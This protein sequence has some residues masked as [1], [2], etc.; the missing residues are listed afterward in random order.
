MIPVHFVHQR[1]FA[2]SDRLSGRTGNLRFL[3]WSGTRRRL[4]RLCLRGLR[5]G[6]NRL[7]LLGHWLLRHWLVRGWL[8]QWSR[9]LGLRILLHWCLRLRSDCRGRGRWRSRRSRSRLR[10]D[11]TGRALRAGAGH[12]RHLLWHLEFHAT[13]WAMKSNRL[14]RLHRERMGRKGLQSINLRSL[15]NLAWCII[16]IA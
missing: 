5:R 2:G 16:W 13:A 15:V 8:L 7:L 12:A 3:K 11:D 14:G 1:R 10:C 6:S 9:R 4:L